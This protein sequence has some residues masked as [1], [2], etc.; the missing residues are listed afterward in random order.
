MKSIITAALIAS[1]MSIA[2]FAAAQTG[3]FQKP[4]I[5]ATPQTPVANVIVIPPVTGSVLPGGPTVIPDG[6]SMASDQE[7][8]AARR[9]YRQ[10]CN[11]VESRGFCECVT[12]G[13]AQALAPAEVRMAART[14]RERITAQGDSAGASVSSDAT[15]GAQNSE[16]RVEQ[17]EGHYADACIQFRS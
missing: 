15:L 12:A 7:V 13:V 5:Y 4:D 17:I 14:I 8:G 2:T 1:A 11:N 6:R 10:Q 3:D 16:Q 9:Y